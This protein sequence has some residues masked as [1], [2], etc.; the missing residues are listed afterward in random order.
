MQNRNQPS[1]PNK[2]PDPSD[3]YERSHPEHESGMGRLDNNDSTPTERPDEQR[4]SV[5]NRQEPD[6]QI[7][8]QESEDDRS[9]RPLTGNL[10]PP[11]AVDHTMNDEEPLGWDQ[12]PQGAQD[13]RHARQPRQEGKGGTPDP[14]DRKTKTHAKP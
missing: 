11:E 14:G 10:P 9:G 7:N 5:P 3:S 2:A 1:E 8:A 6:R 4:D 13:P 12:A